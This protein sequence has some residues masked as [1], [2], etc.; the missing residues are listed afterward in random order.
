MLQWV[1]SSSLRLRTFV[2]ALA[3]LLLVVGGWQLRGVP[4]DAVPEF[5]P[6]SLQVKTEAL[7]LSA[8]EV[9]SLIT[10][11]M[12]ADLLNGVPWL[13]SIESE[14]MTGLSSIEMFFLPGTD[15]MQARQMIQERLTQAH[16]LPNVSK[17]PRL[18]QPVASAGRIMNIGLSSKTVSLIDMSVQAQWTIVPR[19]VGVPGVANVTVWGQRERQLQVLVDPRRLHESKITLEQVVKTAGEA[20]WASPL[21]YLNSS[22]PG[23]GGFIDTPN[24]RLNIRHVSPIV[25]ASEFAKVP[26]QG[27]TTPLGAVASV[28]E[29]HQ[30]LIGDAIVKGGP[31]LMLV[32]EKFPDFNTA[33]VT[34]GVEAALDALRPGMTGIDI[35]TAIY[36]PASFLEQA[37]SNIS[38]GLIAAGVLAVVAFCALLGS[39]RLAFIGLVSMAASLMAAALVLHVRG[40]NFNMMV[41]AGLVLAIG[42]IIDDA[43]A[44]ATHI[45]RRLLEPRT[46][47]DANPPA[48]PILRAVL[49]VRRPALYATLILV[50]AVLPILFMRGLSAAFFQPMIWAYLIAII[51]SMVMA[52]IVTPALALLLISETRPVTPGAEVISGGLRRALEGPVRSGSSSIAPAGVL[53]AAGFAAL[54]LCWMQRDRTLIPSFKETDVLV[55]WQAAPGTSLQAMTKATETLI[56]DI[57]KIPG[58]R[59][60]AAQIG[61]AALSYDVADVN[62]SEVWVSIDPTAPYQDTLD[63]IQRA[64]SLQKGFTGDVETYLSKKMRERL[65]GEDESITVR[66]YGQDPQILRAKAEEVR[67]VLSKIEGIKKPQVE[68]LA[69]RPAINVSVDLDRARD[70]GLKPGDVR[71]YASAMVS[72]ITAGAL[73]HDQKVVDV[74]VWGAPGIRGSEEDVRNLPIETDTGD[75]VKLSEVATVSIAPTVNI[76]RRHGVSR[77]IDIEAEVSGRPLSDVHK[78]V[79]RRIADI[80][81][82]F[83]YHARVMGEHLER[84][85]ALS[86][87]YTYAGASL[88]LIFL[89]LQTAFASWRLAA[90]TLLSLPASLLGGL[91]ITVLLK[92]LSMLGAVLGLFAVLGIAIRNAIMLIQR[93][94]EMEHGNTED[95]AAVVARGLNERFQPIMTTAITTAAVVL[96]FAL[97]GNVAGLEIA[98]PSAL[99][100]LAGLVT[101]TLSSLVVI[102]AL[103]MRSGATAP[104]EESLAI[105]AEST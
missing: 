89:L 11:P 60:A 25:T 36:R 22:T 87:L 52:L 20:V 44:S 2:A 56:K 4:L 69:E 33:E 54:F 58:V 8:V 94:Q 70:H 49:E 71:R 97:L 104:V 66:V 53:I 35:D 18:L 73:F 10:V 43:I 48:Y 101:S 102:P 77:R 83:E 65:T 29:S 72:G 14:S 61:R 74:V 100:I 78:D 62:S 90:L 6:L 50:V 16:A 39:W 47:Q 81:L 19:L 23:S 42:V 96:P 68:Q 80:A 64:A 57:R 79:A 26:V 30:P 34:R 45:R 32:I 21:T 17:P 15:I 85:A 99:V 93:F 5:S 98:N 105:P 86:T 13:K 88:V 95:R 12:E 82:P 24:Q 7:G 76:I 63:A 27:T 1:V 84:R 91:A 67:A 40:V 28:I 51:V 3:A 9:E 55:E 46:A 59:N 38:T 37:R 75:L 41:L 31:G 103:Y 92:D